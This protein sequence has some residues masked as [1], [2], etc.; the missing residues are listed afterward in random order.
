MKHL[1]CLMILALCSPALAA[2]WGLKVGTPELKSATSLAFGPDNVLFVGDA[3][4]AEIIAVNVGDAKAGAT[5]AIDIADLPKALGEVLGG[6]V[7]INDIATNPATGVVY[8]A[9]TVNEKP[10]LATI[11]ASGKVEQFQ[12]KDVAYSAVQLSNAPEDKVSGQ[13]RRR[14]NNRLESI[15]DIAYFEGK[16][17]VSGLRA[18]GAA[19]SVREI[20]FPFAKADEGVGV[21]IYHAAHGR[22]EDYSAMRTFVPLM[23]DGEPSLLGAYICTPLVKI[24]LKDLSSGKDKVNATT[25]AELGN[26]NRPLDMIQYEKAGEEFLL[27][28]NSARGVMKIPAEGLGQQKGLTERVSGGGAAGQPYE[29]VKAWQGVVQMDKLSDTHAVVLLETDGRQS[30]KSVELP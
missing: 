20:D 26:R 16:L 24:S 25:V 29:T 8:A 27:L 4:S 11:D 1:S 10:A 17:L 15:T 12:L 28:S 19:S 2:D 6:K 3:K 7:V 21:Q 18:I 22:E 30:L 5:P 9:V 23:I 14:R 13:G